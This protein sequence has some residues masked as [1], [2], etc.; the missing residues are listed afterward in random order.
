MTRSADLP[1]LTPT[2]HQLATQRPATRI[3]RFKHRSRY[4]PGGPCRVTAIGIGRAGSRSHAARLA[5]ALL[6]EL[7]REAGEL[8]RVARLLALSCGLGPRV[9]AWTTSPVR[10]VGSAKMKAAQGDLGAAGAP[11]CFKPVACPR[12]ETRRRMRRQPRRGPGYPNP[13]CANGI[14]APQ[15]STGHTRFAN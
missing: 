3:H 14:G 1:A 6:G 10:S 11:G 12:R 4:L 7:L 9:L 13:Q 2:V 15:R 8:D 5:G